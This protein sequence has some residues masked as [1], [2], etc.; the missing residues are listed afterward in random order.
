MISKEA[1]FRR[2]KIKEGGEAP[3]GEI[4]PEELENIDKTIKEHDETAKYLEEIA[5]N[6]Y[7]S[8]LFNVEVEMSLD[9]TQRQLNSLFFKRVFVVNNY[10]P[11]KQTDERLVQ[12]VLFMNFAMRN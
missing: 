11:L 2:N 1:L 5:I 12:K 3:E 9:S 6:Y 10:T 4:P 8:Q 7:G